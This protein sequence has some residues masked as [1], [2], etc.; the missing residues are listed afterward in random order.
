[1]DD[2]SYWIYGIGFIAQLLFSARLLI[3]WVRSEKAGRVLSPTIFWQLSLI[4]SLLL[5]LYGALRNDIVIVGGQLVSY[6]IYIRNLRF[7][8]AWRLIPIWFRYGV[9]VWPILIFVY[10]SISERFDFSS[11]LHHEG[12][13]DSLF[14]WGTVGQVIFSFRFIYQ[15]VIAER[16]KKSVLPPGF[17]IISLSG[18]I[19]LIIYG[20]F[21]KDPVVIIGQ[22]FG[23]VIYARNLMIFF[24]EKSTARQ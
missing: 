19:M 15:W 4:A 24:R 22:L 13:V 5:V 11:L 8:R 6:F 21:R 23:S 3:Q 14:I 17:W 20:I 18:S 7:K 12:I 9:I 2:T 10:L 16:M 1:M